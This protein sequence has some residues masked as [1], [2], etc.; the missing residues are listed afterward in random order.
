MKLT[1]LGKYGPYPRAGGACSG[2]LLE[3]GD[4]RLMLDCGSGT[5]SRLQQHVK[6]EDLDAIILSHLHS[7]HMAD[8]LVLRY[9]LPAMVADGRR[10]APLPLYLPQEPADVAGLLRAEKG[11]T[12][13]TVRSGDTVMLQDTKLSF[14]GVRHLVPCNALRVEQGGVSFVYSGDLNTTPG[15]ENFARG[16]DF[17]LIDGCLSCARWSENG[18]HLTSELAAEVARKAGVGRVLITHIH[19]EIEES[20]LLEEARR[21]H[22]SAELAQEGVQYLIK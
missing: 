17:L 22:P 7:D 4:L 9:G 18:P 10:S 6:I 13:H 8:L 16:A 14:F 19:P 1:V 5:L 12:A 20:T 2:Y 3:V 11:F 21:A 15:F